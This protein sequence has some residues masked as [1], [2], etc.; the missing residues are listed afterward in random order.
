MPS[1]LQPDPVTGDYRPLVAERHEIDPLDG[2]ELAALAAPDDTGLE[3]ASIADMPLN[4]L[5][6]KVEPALW[7]KVADMMHENG[8]LQKPHKAAE[9]MS[10]FVKP[11]VV[12]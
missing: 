12:P 2:E 9:Y 10:D 1:L 8:E 6:Y 3:L 4:R 7:R 5:S 11:F